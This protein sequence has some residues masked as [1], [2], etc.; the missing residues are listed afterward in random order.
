[1]LKWAQGNGWATLGPNPQPTPLVTQQPES[2]NAAQPLPSVQ[3]PA[4]VLPSP[5]LGQQAVV[6]GTTTIK[7]STVTGGT[8]E[9][10]S[11]AQV[12]AALAVT[13]VD[14]LRVVAHVFDD[15]LPN[16]APGQVPEALGQL[17]TAVNALENQMQQVRNGQ[18]PRGFV[19]V[20]EALNGGLEALNGLSQEVGILA[21]DV[22]DE[23]RLRS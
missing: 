19:G 14:V 2:A 13:A 11:A 6:N 16:M 8:A 20:Q 5:S 17:N 12:S 23:S 18:W 15:M 3:V 10:T 1:M 9:G 7:P 22:A 21:Q 4:P